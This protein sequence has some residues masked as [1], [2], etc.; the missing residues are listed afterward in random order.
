M[1]RSATISKITATV[2]VVSLVIWL[3][4]RKLVK[5]EH[6]PPR[7]RSFIPLI[8]YTCQVPRMHPWL[9]YSAWAKQYGIF[10]I[11]LCNGPLV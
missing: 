4:S 1:D 10:M 5:Q 9:T 8:G 3:V 6:L 2:I 7:P 11:N